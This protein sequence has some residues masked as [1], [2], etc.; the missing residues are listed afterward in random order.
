M[1]Q[2]KASPLESKAPLDTE[3]EH[4]GIVAREGIGAPELW[5]V[6]ADGSNARLLW[7]AGEDELGHLDWLTWL[8]EKELILFGYVPSG[9]DAIF[10]TL[11]QVISSAGG[12]PKEL[13]VA[14]YGLQVTNSGHELTY[15]RFSL[16]DVENSRTM[17]AT[18]A[19]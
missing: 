18:L 17:R 4:Y 10:Q 5:L 6:D 13:F 16:P 14:G 1:K 3:G 11:Y 15:I 9:T 12:M 2:I 7:A 8:P 19:Y